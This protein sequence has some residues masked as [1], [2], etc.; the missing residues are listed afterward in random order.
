MSETENKFLEALCEAVDAEHAAEPVRAAG[1]GK[2][3]A[4]RVA[5][6]GGLLAVLRGL[7]L[8]GIPWVVILTKILPDVVRK[9]A[10][11]EKI[12]QVIA[13]VLMKWATGG[14]NDAPT[15]GI[16]PQQSTPPESPAEPPP[17]NG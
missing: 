6:G 4:P 10:A 11:G 9:I 17:P 3:A 13:D 2:P 8:A 1:R 15:G 5:I 16:N 7:S 12:V 14:Y